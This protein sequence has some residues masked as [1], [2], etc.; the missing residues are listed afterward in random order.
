VSPFE[1]LTTFSDEGEKAKNHWFLLQFVSQVFTRALLNWL[2]FL[3]EF[4]SSNEEDVCLND[5]LPY[6]KERNGVATRFTAE[7]A[8]TTLF[9]CV[10]GDDNPGKRDYSSDKLHLPH[11]LYRLGYQSRTDEIV[12]QRGDAS[13]DA[14][15]PGT[16]Y[17]FFSLMGTSCCMQIRC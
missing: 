11:G 6:K 8:A 3:P 16:L 14:D 1:L 10:C 7:A 13:G 12:W 17:H 9:L 2:H 15:A 4:L 5:L